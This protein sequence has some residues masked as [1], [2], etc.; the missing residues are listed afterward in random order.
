MRYEHL[1]DA[2]GIMVEQYTL[3]E[4]ANES[5]WLIG[6]DI[7]GPALKGVA[8]KR[9]EWFP[10]TTEKKFVVW[11]GTAGRTMHTPSPAGR[12]ARMEPYR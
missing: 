5:D 12:V 1:S 11:H 6:A 8:L 3:G 10:D 9:G 7:L 4:N 2:S